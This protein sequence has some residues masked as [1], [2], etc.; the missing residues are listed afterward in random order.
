MS[1]DSIHTVPSGDG[2]ANRRAGSERAHSVADSVLADVR[3]VF[4]LNDNG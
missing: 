2:W 3:D 4:F 1:R